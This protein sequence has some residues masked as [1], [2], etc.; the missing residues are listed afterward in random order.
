[1]V[2]ELRGVRA[3]GGVSTRRVGGLGAKRSPPRAPQGAVGLGVHER[4]CQTAAGG[5][6]THI[7]FALGLE[8]Q[9]LG[10]LR[11]L[12]EQATPCA[13]LPADAIR[14]LRPQYRPVGQHE[15][16]FVLERP[17]RRLGVTL[18]PNDFT[19]AV[20]AIARTTLSDFGLLE[21]LFTQIERVLKINELQ[22]I[23]NDEVEAA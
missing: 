3:C 14:R 7:A 9:L 1:M 17:W 15:L 20:A 5:N 4:P 6:H 16:R 10:W 12:I 21:R 11:N 19:H 22:A 23:T 13:A 18:D 2:K 8:D